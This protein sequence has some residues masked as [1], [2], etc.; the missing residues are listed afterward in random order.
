MNLLSEEQLHSCC[1]S[2]VWIRTVLDR[3]PYANIDE[4]L[5]ESDKI[6]AGLEWPEIELALAAHPRI[7]QRA[8]GATT[9]AKWSRQEQSAAATDDERVAAEL[10]DGNAAYEQ[11]FDRVFLICATGL[12]AAEILAA[13]KVRLDNDDATEAAATRTELAKIVRLRLGRIL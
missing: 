3:Q 5:A 12:S 7:G 1:A 2:P 11:R 4:V 8:G 6:I 9:E 13:L 10:A